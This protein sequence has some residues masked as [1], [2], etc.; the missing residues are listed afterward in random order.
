MQGK[1]VLPKLKQPPNLLY[2]LLPG[3]DGVSKEFIKNVHAHNMMFAFTSLGGRID[4]S[5]NQG[6]GAYVFRMHWQNYH[7][8][9]SLLPKNGQELNLA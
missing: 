9:G 2:N 3:K 5:I 7:M 1:V 6:F 8:M 4:I